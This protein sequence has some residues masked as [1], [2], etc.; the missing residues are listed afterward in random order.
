M[1]FIQVT[2]V[3]TGRRESIPVERILYI[4]ED[5]HGCAFIAESR[6]GKSTYGVF[7]AERYEKIL[8][9]LNSARTFSFDELPKINHEDYEALEQKINRV[10]CRLDKCLKTIKQARYILSSMVIPDSEFSKIILARVDKLL[11]SALE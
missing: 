9:N 5:E 1:K 8:R 7:T 10:S 2:N 6:K 4:S 3:G 11:E